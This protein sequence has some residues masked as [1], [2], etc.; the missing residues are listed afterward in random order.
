MDVQRLD[1]EQAAALRAQALTYGPVGATA[2]Q[3]A[4]A[5][6]RRFERSRTLRRRDFDGA[7]EEL[8]TWQLHRR[9]GLRVRASET[10]LSAGTV[11]LMRLGLGPL[12]VRVPCRVVDL[13]DEPRCR[14]FAYG[15]LPGHPEAGEERFELRQHDDGG[16][17]LT[18]TAF[19]RPATRLARV[20]GPVGR[21]VQ[22][23]MTERYL[24]A[25]DENA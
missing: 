14:G 7:A 8:L 3:A 22:D 9:A 23:V 17:E 21:W 13:I 15:T 5:G 24:R 25:L 1:A 20:L 10:P 19:S 18:I 4:P 11:V 16:L 12:S 6:W 2:S